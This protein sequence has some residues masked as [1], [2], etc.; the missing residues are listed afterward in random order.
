MLSSVTAFCN[1]IVAKAIY[2]ANNKKLYDDPYWEILLHYKAGWDGNYRSLVDDPK[3][4]LS[5]KGKYDKK[6]ELEATIKGILSKQVVPDEYPQCRFPARTAWLKDN[7]NIV[8][9]NLP[10]ADCPHFDN[11]T[12]TIKPYSATLVFPFYSLGDPG[13]TFGHTMLRLE[14]KNS[15]PLLG[16]AVSYAADAGDAGAF[17]FVMNG[18]SG[19]FNGVYYVM[20]YSKKLNEY[21]AIEQR[22]VW[23]YELNMTPDEVWRMYLHI[24]EMSLVTTEYYFFD[25]NCAYNLLFFF[26]AARPGITLTDGY[27]W[28]LPVDTIRAAERGGFISGVKYIPSFQKRMVAISDT[29]SNSGVSLAKDIAAGKQQPE[30]VKESGLSVRQQIGVLDLSSELVRQ[31]FRTYKPGELEIYKQRSFDI[32]MIR[33]QYPQK[34]NYPVDQPSVPPE[35]GHKPSRMLFGGGYA[36]DNYMFR[37]EWRPVY[38]SLMDN[39][40]GYLEG[41]NVEVFDTSVRYYPETGKFN[42]EQLKLVE[43]TSLSPVSRLFFPPS[44]HTSMGIRDK[45]IRADRTYMSPYMQLGAGLSA[46]IKGDILVWAL[47]MGAAEGGGQHSGYAYVGGGGYGGILYST[48]SFSK[49]LAESRYMWYSDARNH[50]DGDITLKYLLYPAINHAVSIEA[51]WVE[52]SGDYMSQYMLSYMFYF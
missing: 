30:S 45:T 1:D 41:G 22:D 35:K 33:A 34:N 15:A 28:V 23:E 9:D 7:L 51:K 6:A 12:A 25:E 38:H 48:G 16:Y 31:K 11:I 29:I 47:A 49:F 43:L 39:P 3:F 42:L 13:S 24:W 19:G 14:A 21:A 27:F 52:E 17:S 10:E 20:P 32:S 18:V 5:T 26:E 50:S 44:W 4:F 46:Y 36:D 8:K 2:E 37:I 40:T